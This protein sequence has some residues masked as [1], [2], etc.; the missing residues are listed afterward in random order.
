MNG[1]MVCEKPCLHYARWTTPAD[2]TMH[3]GVRL[4]P[5]IARLR[6][7]YV[8]VADC[9]KLLYCVDDPYTCTQR[10]QAAAPT[11]TDPL[12]QELL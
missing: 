1:I 10:P 4:L 5:G 6:P 7:S 11:N 12:P 9:A 2:L 8:F 3:A